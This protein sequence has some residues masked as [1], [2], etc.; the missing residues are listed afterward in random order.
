ML[1]SVNTEMKYA[2]V[3]SE[4][5]SLLAS[6][7]RKV[8]EYK[9]P[10]YLV[11]NK[12][13]GKFKEVSKIYVAMD[14]HLET[15]LLVVEITE[16]LTPI[17]KANVLNTIFQYNYL[18]E[19]VELVR[20]RGSFSKLRRKYVLYNIETGVISIVPIESI[21]P[22]FLREDHLIYMP[23][24]ARLEDNRHLF[25]GIPKIFEYITRRMINRSV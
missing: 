23:L 24:K 21:E 2:E 15:E 12:L 17:E 8:K 6:I 13:N 1:N 19:V 20:S 9:K 11:V 22:S 16:P 25:R 7:E 18:K 10:Y 5:L 4:F 14:L 3:E